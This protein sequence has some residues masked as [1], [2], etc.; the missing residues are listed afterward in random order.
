MPDPV[1]EAG[2]VPQL[3][4]L[5]WKVRIDDFQIVL[6]VLSMASEN[7]KGALAR[8]AARYNVERWAVSEAIDRVEKALGIDLLRRNARQSATPTFYGKVVLEQGPR[9]IE[10][11]RQLDRDLS[12]IYEHSLRSA[13]ETS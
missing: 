7:P 10:A 11:V 1:G 8:A 3:N 2:E 12:R 9:V 5:R 4:L 13:D 6:T